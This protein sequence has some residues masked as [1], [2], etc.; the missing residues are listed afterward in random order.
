MNRNVQLTPKISNS[1]FEIFPCFLSYAKLF[2]HLVNNKEKEDK[3][4][5]ME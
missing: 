3:D 2:S 1:S 5:K 4:E